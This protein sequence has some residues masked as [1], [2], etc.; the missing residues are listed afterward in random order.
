MRDPFSIHKEEGA[1]LV[2]GG[3]E[4]QEKMGQIE[5][6]ESEALPKDCNKEDF[7]KLGF[8]FGEDIDELFIACKLPEGWKKQGSDHDMW[9]YIVDDKGRRRASV[10]YKAAFYDRKAG[11][12]L[13]H[14]FS[15][16]SN[17]AFK[18]DIQYLVVDN[19]NG[20]RV[21][22][23]EVLPNTKENHAVLEEIYES[24]LKENYPDYKNPMAYWEE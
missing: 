7:E 22:E 2:P 15:V 18:Q 19:V 13:T 5:M 23:T 4:L 16:T 9:S 6:V 21:F 10:F 24:W 11:I 20:E 17:Y 3:I 14:R 8:V 1:A 12:S